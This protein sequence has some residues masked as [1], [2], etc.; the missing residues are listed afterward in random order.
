M[1][2]LPNQHSNSQI[3]SGILLAI[4]LILT[5]EILPSS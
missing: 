1:T 3:I 4:G 5:P 2:M